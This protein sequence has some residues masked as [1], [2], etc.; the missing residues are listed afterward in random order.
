VGLRK[1]PMSS[2]KTLSFS[3]K[4]TGS[5]RFF[6]MFSRYVA[7]ATVL[8]L[9]LFF[10]L[11]FAQ[12]ELRS[13]TAEELAAQGVTNNLICDYTIAYDCPNWRILWEEPAVIEAHLQ[14]IRRLRWLQSVYGRS[15]MLGDGEYSAYMSPQRL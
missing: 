11:A 8:C 14:R 2:H 3:S 4:C 9:A 5:V 6:S 13:P 7:K 15:V 10:V 12:M 1:Q